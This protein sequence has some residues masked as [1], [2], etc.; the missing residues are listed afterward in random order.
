[1]S[2]PVSNVVENYC[3][4]V[5]S[6]S[7]STFSKYALDKDKKYTDYY[8]KRALDTESKASV[9]LSIPYKKYNKPDPTGQDA[10]LARSTSALDKA[11]DDAQSFHASDLLA[12]LK[13][14]LKNIKLAIGK[15][16]DDLIAKVGEIMSSI[17]IANLKT[18]ANNYID[19]ISNSLKNAY[20]NAVASFK[21]QMDALNAK[22]NLVIASLK[23][24]IATVKNVFSQKPKEIKE[25]YLKRDVGQSSLSKVTQVNVKSATGALKADKSILKDTPAAKILATQLKVDTN[26]TTTFE[27]NPIA[28]AL[29]ITASL[30][31][32]VSSKKIEEP[33]PTDDKAEYGKVQVKENKAGFQEISDE[34]PGNVRKVSMHPTGTYNSM[35]DNGDYV[36]KVTGN[37]M[38]MNDSDWNI[39]TTKDKVEIVVGDSKI[40][41][42]KN[43]IESITGDVNSNVEGNVNNVVQ[44]EVT[45]DLKADYTGKIEGDYKENVEGDKTE[46][47]GGDV[48]EKISG[49]HKENVTGALTITVIGNVNIT[50][51]SNVKVTAPIVNIMGNGMVKISSSAMVQISAPLI[52]LG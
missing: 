42:R 21:G 48:T 26:V 41:I 16:V 1:M 22:K 19:Q 27:Q 36:T 28:K 31:P 25:N 32:K 23:N 6:E 44:G 43:F 24:S 12:F 51:A 9:E 11:N 10:I 8:V 4:K 49:D 50:S 5:S 39:K 46:K 38:D 45:N 34:T 33:K 18:M 52:K 7:T 20:N 14:L 29:G 17:T 15:F 2:D 35:L 37:K 13:G 30:I 3:K 47:T 40:E